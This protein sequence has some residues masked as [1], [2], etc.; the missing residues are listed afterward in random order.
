M[1]AED[2]LERGLAGI[3]S[4]YDV[5]EGA[6]DR[7][8][9]QLAP[10][11]EDDD[12]PSWRDH[13]RRPSMRGWMMLAAAAIVIIVIASF[14]V[15]GGGN[16]LNHTTNQAGRFDSAGGGTGGGGGGSAPTAQGA[17]G[18]PIKHAARA[19]VLAPVGSGATGASSGGTTVVTGGTTSGTTSV[20][21]L[22]AVPDKIIKTGELDLQVQKGK[23]GSTLD[24][25]TGLA[26]FEHGYI[27]NSRTSEGGFAPSGEIT[28]RVPV[29]A[30]D[31]AVQRARTITGVR[32][33]GLNTSGKDVT[34]KYVDLKARIHA[35]E[36]TRRTFLTILERATTIG[37]T[38]AVQQHITDV[39]TQIDQLKGQKKVLVNQAALS[40][41][42]VTVDQKVVAATVKTHHKSGLHKAVDRSVS[43][44]VHGIEAIIGIIGPLLLAAL[45]IAL[46]FVAGKFGYRALRRRMV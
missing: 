36:K 9:E 13:M 42:T 7:I 12:S 21:P 27:A 5:P 43:R 29:A 35:L 46:F 15:G 11:V 17:V 14:A 33:L 40:T 39:Q 34:S 25:L 22:P 28:M 2:L 31:D 20:T 16:A 8:S 4:D 30:F 26:T 18:A 3:A 23:V 44:F 38:L 10:M 1:I 45:L 32:V 41:L 24:R 19:P 37:E 6:V